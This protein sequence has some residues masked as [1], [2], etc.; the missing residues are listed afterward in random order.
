MFCVSVEFGLSFSKNMECSVFE[1]NVL[2]K[3]FKPQRD[4]QHNNRLE[5]IT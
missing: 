3:V 2:R 5:R 4:E 1:N